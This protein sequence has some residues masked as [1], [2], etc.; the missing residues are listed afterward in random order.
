MVHRKIFLYVVLYLASF[1]TAD[2]LCAVVSHADEAGA[3]A[4][5]IEGAK[6]EGTL[7]YYTSVNQ[8]DASLMVKAFE[9]KYPFVKISMLRTPG[10]KLF[11]RALAEAR[12][13][14]LPA[15]VYDSSI[16]QVLQ[17]KENGLLMKY[18]GPENKAYP[19]KFRDPE[20]YWNATFHLPYVITYNTK[21]ISPQEAPKSYEDLLNPKWRG[22]IGMD[23][24]DVQWFFHMQKIMGREKGIDYMRKLA[25]QNVSFRKGHTLLHTLCAAGEIPILVVGYL[26]G[27]ETAKA[28]GAPIDWVR[29]AS[30]P[31]ITAIHSVAVV[32]SAPHPNAAKLFYNFI[33]SRDGAK[34]F[35]KVQ[36]ISARPD[37]Q[38]A[39]IK[40]MDFYVAF[41]GELM[42]NY[43]PVLKEWEEI[44]FHR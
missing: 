43:K 12:A 8:G 23:A 14:K 9:E 38:A 27:V 4:K 34:V 3:T 40:N 32:A 1:S 39:D 36:R 31:I 21:I 33:I 15:D 7:T 6:K 26:S 44:F 22:K 41:P 37:E 17:M 13:K 11:T 29:F 24:E 25:R 30:F 42:A 35:K 19:A 2:L 18:V 16:V 20:G 5:L 10:E 28:G